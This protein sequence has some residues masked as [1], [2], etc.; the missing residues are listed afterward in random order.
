LPEGVDVA[1]VVVVVVVVVAGNK[2]ENRSPS[3]PTATTA[4]LFRLKAYYVL[5]LN[6]IARKLAL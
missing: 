3:T 5:L 2:A 1:P 4:S 6:F